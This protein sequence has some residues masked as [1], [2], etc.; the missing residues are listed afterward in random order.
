MVAEARIT[1]TE[2]GTDYT[3]R[4]SIPASSGDDGVRVPVEVNG[5][6]VY[7]WLDADP[8]S[9]PMG[10]ERE[11]ASARQSLDGALNDLSAVAAELSQ[12]LR[13]LDAS[14]VKIEFGC[15]FALE[16]GKIVA[17]IGK[18]SAK[19]TFKVGLE[20]TRPAA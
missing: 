16:S 14:A 17:V 19:S 4:M 10:E 7:L 1:R 8:A 13:S 12:R 18:A 20:W 15:E 5:H 6:K 2:T 11:I 3:A 9:E